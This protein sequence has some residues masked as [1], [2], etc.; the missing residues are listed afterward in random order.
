[1]VEAFIEEGFLSFDDLE[2]MDPAQLA[3]L[4]GITEEQADDIIV[5]AEDA[6]ERVE[7]ETKAARAAAD[8]AEAEAAASG[9][10]VARPAARSGA[11]T[12]ADLFPEDG[13][14]KTEEARPTVESLFG[15]DTTETPTEQPLSAAQVFG[16]E[17]AAPGPESKEES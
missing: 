15:P 3:E 8:A 11:P 1:M 14:A 17:K 4:A 2:I 9:E 13:S 16:D 5:F 10:V 12:A 7:E 6:A